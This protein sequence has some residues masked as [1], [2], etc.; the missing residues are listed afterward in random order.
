MAWRG[1]RLAPRLH[2]VAVLVVFGDARIDVAVGDVDV[3]SESQATSVGWR[4]SPSIGGER[5]IGMAPRLGVFVGGFGAASKDPDDAA[6]RIE[7]DD[8]VGAFV[9]GPDVVVLVDAHGVSF[10]PGVEALADLAQ[11]F[12]LRP[13]LEQLRRRQDA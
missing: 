5:R 8:H 3:A 12:T 10:G 7:L 13:E 4:K 1:S 11:E 2:P 6:G 9:D